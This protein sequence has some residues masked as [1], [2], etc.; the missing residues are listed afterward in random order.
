[1][2]YKQ[3]NNNRAGS[4][5]TELHVLVL[6]QAEFRMHWPNII[7]IKFAHFPGRLPHWT[8]ASPHVKV[9]EKR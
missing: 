6:P 8:F 2:Q 7:L 4:W 5:L 3:R 1:M 9:L